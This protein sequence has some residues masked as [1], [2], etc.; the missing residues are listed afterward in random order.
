[1]KKATLIGRLIAASLAVGAISAAQ[2]AVPSFDLGLASGYS[3]F[4]YGNVSQVRDV[5]GR[6]A[7]GGNLTTSGFS[8]AYRT[9]VPTSLPSVVVGKNVALT[10]GTIYANP[11][12]G[13]DTNVTIGPITDYTKNWNG[14]G[15]YGGTNSSSNYLSLTKSNDI[16]SVVNFGAA[17]TSFTALS[18]TL[19][20]AAAN[21]SVQIDGSGTHLTGNNTSGLQVF[22]L[23]SG[24]LKNLVLSNVKAGSTVVINV[25]G[26]TVDF[27]GGQDGQLQAL[28]A[29]VIY[30]LLDAD[31]VNVNT[32]VYGSVLANKAELRGAGHLEGNI[33]A[34][35]MNGTVEIGYEPFHGYVTTP[36]PEPTTYAMLL[37]GLGLMGV[38]AR[39]RKSA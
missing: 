12:A 22:N 35:S 33:I 5:E 6:L 27:T 29:N 32:F 19:G 20:S 2:A 39:R 26:S 10:G 31:V 3:A 38:V 23:S 37:G 25:S 34:N 9:Q 18:S 1:M 30:N 8:F 24:N 17:K 15:V 36:V 7:V 21:G 4:F 13:I 14:F 28:R 16:N 11:G